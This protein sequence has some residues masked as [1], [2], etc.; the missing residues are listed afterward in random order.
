MRISSYAVISLALA[1]S[2]GLASVGHAADPC[3]NDAK[4]QFTE[5]K[6]QCKEDYQA[7]KDACLNRDHDCMEG[8]RAGREECSLATG[9]DESLT[10]CRDALRDAKATCRAIYAEG[11]PALDQCIEAGR[12][13]RSRRTC[14][15][16][17]SRPGWRRTRCS[18]RERE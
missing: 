9:L 13:W 7:A 15:R 12:G 11:T 10:A 3:I 16:A 2:L 4:Q 8:C 17:S 14:T 1:S 5:T 18:A 6:A